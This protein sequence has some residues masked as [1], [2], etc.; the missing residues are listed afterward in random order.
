M[1]TI[2]PLYRY[3]GA[4]L[5]QRAV[6]VALPRAGATMV[7]SGVVIV[8]LNLL[9]FV[10]SRDQNASLRQPPPTSANLRQPP[11]RAW[12]GFEDSSWKLC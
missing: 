8:V 2:E 6:L 7:I 11:P 3:L 1:Q 5:K 12:S 10:V 4:A 9:G